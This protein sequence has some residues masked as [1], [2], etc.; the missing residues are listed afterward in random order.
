MKRRVAAWLL[1]AM[2]VVAGWPASAVWAQAKPKDTG[3]VVG[4]GDGTY[5]QAAGVSTVGALDRVV[6]ELDGVP[7]NPS[8][9]DVKDAS[10]RRRILEL[11]LQMD[12]NAFAYDKVKLKGYR[13]LVDRAY[14]SAGVY[15]DVSVYEKELAP[16]TVPQPVK[17]Q[18]LRE[19]NEALAIFRNGGQRGEL[20]SFLSAPEKNIRKG[21]GPGL[22]DLTGSRASNNLDAVGNAAEFQ[23]GIVRYLQ[24]ADL[25]VNNI[26]D[27]NQA[28]QF[29]LIR[30]HMR[31]VVILSAMYP[32]I[33]DATRDAIKPIDDLVD[34][35]GDVMDAFNSYEFAQQNG[36]DTDK[37]AAELQRE[38]GVAQTSKN[39]FIDAHALD[40][41][42]LQLN[43]V[44][45]AHRH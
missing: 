11:R 29:H 31:D 42:A 12:F 6:S 15:Q 27:P 35:Y 14:E 19:M 36:M 28:A 22:W 37:V 26:T 38:F 17:D 34:D 45:D 23:S 30:K 41:L 16:Q 5:V 9:Q 39:A 7:N 18:R 2:M 21:G 4:N 43:G 20:R 24:G 3:P 13:D 25:G 32:P 33:S 10:W 40:A 1:I 8:P 44:R